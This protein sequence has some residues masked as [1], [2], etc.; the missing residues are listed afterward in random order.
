MNRKKHRLEDTD[1][2]NTAPEADAGGDSVAAEDTET[3]RQMDRLMDEKDRA[4][5]A[6]DEYLNLAQRLKADFENYKRRNQNTREDAY[7]DGVWDTL[8]KFLPVLDN[9]DRAACSGGGEESLRE[10]VQLVIKQF[11]AILSAAGVE[12]IAA[13]DCAFDPNLHHAVMQ[14]PVDGR[15]S[16]II[17]GVLQKG[18]AKDGK[19]LRH[20]MVKVAE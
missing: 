1:A 7:N 6:R 13:C 4:E 2:E 3:A 9:L 11:N 20:C 10:G 19:I 5:E 12:E 17:V 18:Y 16:G 14:E 8:G 15:E